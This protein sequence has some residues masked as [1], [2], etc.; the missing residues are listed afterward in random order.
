[1]PNTSSPVI[2]ILGA[3]SN[4]G[5]H[6]AR[7]FSAKGYRVALAARRAN[8]AD[9]TADLVNI[10]SDLSDP[11]SV[12]SAF[13]KVKTL[14]G[15]PR[16]VIYNG[17]NNRY[18]RHIIEFL[19]IY[20][21][22]KSCWANPEWCEESTLTAIGRFQSRFDHQHDQRLCRCTTSCLGLRTTPQLRFKDIHLHR[23]YTEYNYHGT[24]SRLGCRQVGHCTHH[25]VS[26]RSIQRPRI[27]V[28]K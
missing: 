3:G 10:P 24:I 8:E 20:F 7:A 2:L 14:L 13:S 4:V 22:S 1:M 18:E 11:N 17:E 12:I 19:L 26:C 9:N 5:Q 28:C 23:K 6:V 15:V 21:I 27:Q 16:V 25:W